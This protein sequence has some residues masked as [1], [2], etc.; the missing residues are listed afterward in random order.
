[1]A[2]QHAPPADYL[3]PEAVYP[4]RTFLRIAGLSQTTLWRIEHAEGV[5]LDR[6]KASQKVYVEGK[7]GIAFLR[8][9]ARRQSEATS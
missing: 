2:I 6:I 5:K 3:L 7:A 9:R 4:L 8:E 1:M